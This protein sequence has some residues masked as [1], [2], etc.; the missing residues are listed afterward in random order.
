MTALTT[1]SAVGHP[2]RFRAWPALQLGG[3]LDWWNWLFIH[4]AFSPTTAPPQCP[5]HLVAGIYLRLR[6]RPG[7]A[8]LGVAGISALDPKTVVL[9]LTA[10][11]DG[12]MKGPD[13]RRDLAV[14]AARAS[15]SARGLRPGQP[16]GL[17]V[18]SATSDGCC[19]H[20]PLRAN[21][22][23]EGWEQS[24]N[25]PR[26]RQRR[27]ALFRSPVRGRTCGTMTVTW[28]RRYGCMAGGQGVAGS[29][30]AVP[31]IIRTVV[32]RNGNRKRTTG[33]DHAALIGWLSAEQCCAMERPS[34]WTAVHLMIR[35]HSDR[36]Y[37]DR[38]N[39][40]S[41]G[42]LPMRPANGLLSF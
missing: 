41:L 32:P 19:S 30:P 4:I 23:C 13:H 15:T 21:G 29:N 40:R 24:G 1:P 18:E 42:E 9:L 7:P 10:T 11:I 12:V 2:Q 35:L 26:S 17:I 20:V 22:R 38:A 36:D 39:R 6:R 8:G 27:T 34:A 28:W 31:T 25:H 5:A 16:V 33:N 3:C 14:L 37:R